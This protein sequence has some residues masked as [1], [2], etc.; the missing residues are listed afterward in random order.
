MPHLGA[1]SSGAFKDGKAEVPH[2]TS[3]TLKPHD[4]WWF[5]YARL[6]EIQHIKLAQNMSCELLSS[7]CA[8]RLSVKRLARVWLSILRV[9][10]HLQ[11]CASTHP[12][13]GTVNSSSLNNAGKRCQNPPSVWCSSRFHVPVPCA[14]V[15]WPLPGLGTSFSVEQSCW[16]PAVI[17]R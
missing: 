9:S 7:E 12:L 15:A 4:F 3:R 10:V 14:Q 5:C 16:C 2:F 6:S 11:S 17:Y 8:P 1:N 13:W